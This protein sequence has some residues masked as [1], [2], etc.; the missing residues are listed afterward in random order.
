LAHNIVG[1]YFAEVGILVAQYGPKNVVHIGESK[2]LHY[3]A[4]GIQKIH[5]DLPLPF[6]QITHT[7]WLHKFVPGAHTHADPRGAIP[8]GELCIGVVEGSQSA[9]CTHLL[10]CASK[11]SNIDSITP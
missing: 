6:L 1:N 10:H 5:Q 9:A 8:S 3:L 7:V 2:S 4:A 11:K